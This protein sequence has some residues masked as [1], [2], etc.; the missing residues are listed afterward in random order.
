ML[1]SDELR[2]VVNVGCAEFPENNVGIR[3]VSVRLTL[4]NAKTNTDYFHGLVVLQTLEHRRTDRKNTSLAITGVAGQL[5]QVY[6][7]N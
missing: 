4:L 5:V 6:V 7:H 1:H 2:D 3:I